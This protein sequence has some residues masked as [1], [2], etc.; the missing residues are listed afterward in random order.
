VL[1]PCSRSAATI[2]KGRP[3]HGPQNGFRRTGVGFCCAS[4]TLRVTVARPHSRLRVTLATRRPAKPLKPGE[5][6]GGAWGAMATGR[7]RMAATRA[8]RRRGLR[9]LSGYEFF[10]NGLLKFGDATGVDAPRF[11]RATFAAA[12]AIGGGGE[13]NREDLI[14]EVTR[15]VIKIGLSSRRAFRSGRGVSSRGIRPRAASSSSAP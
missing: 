2:L 15:A 13:Y 6:R 5:Q 10:E 11:L 12:A 1:W 4:Q 7:E 3:V 9:K 8:R 14:P